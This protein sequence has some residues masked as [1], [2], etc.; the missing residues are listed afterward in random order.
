MKRMGMIRWRWQVDGPLVTGYSQ[1]MAQASGLI[2]RGERTVVNLRARSA[3]DQL[4]PAFLIT[5]VKGVFR[6]AGAWL[7]E[8]AARQALNLNE[9]QSPRYIT[10]DFGQAVP[11]KWAK[12]RPKSQHALCPAC[13]V[14]GGA[15]CLSAGN[16]DAPSLRLKSPVS[17]SFDDG[18]DAFH[19]R[20]GEKKDGPYRF[21]WEQADNK[22]KPLYIERLLQPDGGVELVARV[23]NAQD[24]HIALLFLAGDLISSGFFRFGR[25]TTRG[26]GVVRL[27]PLACLNVDLAELLSAESAPWQSI[28]KPTAGWQAAERILGAAPMRVLENYVRSFA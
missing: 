15:G 6:T 13:Q 3:P 8:R 4:E 7:L 22:G 28:E 10:C 27:A 26:Y 17:F 2:E 5:S 25:F 14:F 11:D 19:S 1:S 9:A 18:T 12:L 20:V 16:E 23:E 21:A 24:H